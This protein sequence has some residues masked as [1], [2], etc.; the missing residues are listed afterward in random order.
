MKDDLAEFG[1]QIG[2]II[3]T[4]R[5]LDGAELEFEVSVASV[6]ALQQEEK[7][8]AWAELFHDEKTE[9]MGWESHIIDEGAEKSLEQHEKGQMEETLQKLAEWKALPYQIINADKVAD[10]VN[11]RTEQLAKEANIPVGVA[12]AVLLK[13]SWDIGEA[14]KAL[15]DAGYL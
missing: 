5:T 10:L 14:K 15:L 4:P 13:N 9:W 1:E 7:K 2:Q 12:H 6:P 11:D 3:E 8:S